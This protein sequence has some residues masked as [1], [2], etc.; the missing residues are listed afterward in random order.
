MEEMTRVWGMPHANTFSIK[1]IR[2][3]VERAIREHPGVWVDPFAN[4]SALRH[5]LTVTND[6][7]PAMPTDFH[8]DA[9][10]FLRG[11][12]TAS[13]DGIVFDP[14]FSIHQINTVYAGF[15]NERPVKQSTRYYIEMLRVL[16]PGGVVITCGWNSNGMPATMKRDERG[17]QLKKGKPTGCVLKRMLVCAHGGGHNDTLVCEFRKDGDACA[18]KWPAQREVEPR[19]RKH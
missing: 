3:F 5:L 17:Q 16:K 18:Y 13:V 2:T 8:M 19:K 9:L 14:P 7:N 6:L 4:D 15:G 12:E 1:P 10:E 11:R